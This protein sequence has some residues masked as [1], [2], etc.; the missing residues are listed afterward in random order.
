VEFT[1]R[2]IRRRKTDPQDGY[3]AENDSDRQRRGAVDKQEIG[4]PEVGGR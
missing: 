4:S 2:T 1:D 3:A